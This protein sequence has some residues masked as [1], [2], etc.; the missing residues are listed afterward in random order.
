MR[1]EGQ[2]RGWRGRA[3]GPRPTR[4]LGRRPSGEISAL[5]GGATYALNLRRACRSLLL[6]RGRG[7]TRSFTLPCNAC[8]MGLSL[9]WLSVPSR[10]GVIASSVAKDAC[11]T[12]ITPSNAKNRREPVRF[13][14]S[15]PQK[16][17]SRAFT[18][19]TAVR[20][21]YSRSNFFVARGNEGKRRMSISCG[22]RTV[23]P[24]DFPALQ[25]FAIGHSQPSC[26]AGQRYLIV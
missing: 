25:M 2:S 22:T 8:A 18:R 19:S 13:P 4:G 15:A 7:G 20:P 5:G 14:S 21:L 23:R 10:R 16:I 24:Y 26:I 3:P 12:M 9:V 6:R 17:L 11:T 1:S